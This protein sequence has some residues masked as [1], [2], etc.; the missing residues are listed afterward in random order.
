MFMKVYSSN[1]HGVILSAVTKLARFI[2]PTYGAAGRGILIDK[3]F[4]Q[5]VFDDGYAAVEE[6]ELEDELE[7]AVI[8]YVKEATR[9]TNKRAG[10]GTTTSVILMSA[11]ID[12]ALTEWQDALVKPDLNEIAKEIEAASKKVV[13]SIT[14][15]AKKIKTVAELERIA[16]NS[17]A[18]PEVA[19]M[20]ADLVHAV[21][22]DGEVAI[23]NSETMETTSEV[24]KGMTLDRGYI[25]QYMAGKDSDTVTLTNPTIII[26][27]EEIQTL[28]PIFPVIEEKLKQGNKDFLIIAQDVTGLA[29]QALV[30]NKLKGN[31][32]AVAIKA[33]GY[34]DMRYELLED[35]ATLTGATFMTD[36]KGRPIA[37]ITLEDVGTAKKID[38]NKD[39][40]LILE[41]AGKD[42]ALKARVDIIRPLTEKGSEFD[43]DKAKTRIAK[44]TGGIGVIKVGANT[45]TEQRAKKMKIEDAV[46][47]TKLAFKDGVIPGVAVTYASAKSGS[48][49]LDA[50]LQA[51]YGVLVKNGKKAISED[52]QDAAGVAIA[53]LE[54]AVSLAVALLTTGGISAPKTE[55]K[56]DN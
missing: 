2:E 44:L 26:T 43:K 13:A 34:G 22:K 23:E 28:D 16:Q 53:S 21:G 5:D 36:K 49:I 10:D 32:N 8:K 31:I 50:A 27:D 52:I 15:Q 24:V 19:E 25:S 11:I 38:V 9:K 17:Y 54:S 51:P 6:F 14:K 12:V 46:H 55:K 30:V 56:D 7:N 3:G 4:I 45:E 41:G 20:I 47:S 37:S 48:K 29:L 18:N 35:I 1:P 33:P 39:E 42:D 40:T